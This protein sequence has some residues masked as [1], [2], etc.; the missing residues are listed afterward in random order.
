MAE[1][2]ADSIEHLMAELA[3][4][5]VRLNREVVIA[6]D[7]TPEGQPDDMRGLV[8]TENEIDALSAQPD[9]LLERWRRQ[10]RLAPTLAN[11]DQREEALRAE[12][13]QRTAASR[14]AGIPLALPFIAQQF[15][16]SSVE[17]DLLLIAVAPEIETR[18]ETLY[19][20]LQNDVT[21]KRPSADL[22]LH[23]VS[24]S[25]RDKLGNRRLLVEGSTLVA[26]HLILLGEEPHDRQPTFFRR[27]LKP[28]EGVVGAVLSRGPEH[29]TERALRLPAPPSGAPDVAELTRRQLEQLAAQ[30]RAGVSRPSIVRLVGARAD[31]LRSTADWLADTLRRSAILLELDSLIKDPER[32]SRAVRDAR[33]YGSILIVTAP[34]AIDE[35]LGRSLGDAETALWRALARFPDLVV[36][37]GDQTTYRR[38]PHGRAVWRV[39][40]DSPG[41][42]ARR[43]RWEDA[44]RGTLTPDEVGRLASTFRFGRQQIDHVVS[45]SLSAARLRDPS[46]VQ[47]SFSDILEAG[48]IATSPELGR[49][50]VRVEPRYKW[51]DLILPPE[52]HEQLRRLADWVR[53]RHT[54]HD[55]WGFGR[56]LSRGKGL[57]VLFT[58]PSGTGKTMAAEV[59]AGELGL[60]LFQIDLA[61][62]TSKYIGET[63]K[64]LST[65]FRKAEDCQAVLFFDEADALFGKRTEV[66]DAHDR[67]ANIEVNFLLQRV[68]QYE[69]IVI[70]ASNLQRNLDDAFLRRLHDVVEFPFPNDSLRERMWRSHVPRE[71]RCEKDIDYA[72]LGRQFKITGGSIKNIVLDAAFRAASEQRPIGMRDLIHATKAELQKQGRLPSKAEFDVWYDLIVPQPTTNERVGR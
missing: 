3:R 64:N 55:E 49:F 45:L 71:A 26:D 50:T 48:R 28:H 59:L 52:K 17:I 36:L 72:F 23:L 44:L 68:E 63:E 29:L 4:L 20:Y 32:G 38:L 21:R 34:E 27:Y 14:Q 57:N 5:D 31:D 22:A 66:K 62:V 7:A 19:A 46:I 41:Y 61:S 10:E 11:F 2:Y 69:G 6:R 8:I 53:H 47:P 70:L 43:R 9:Y 58:G 65:I 33:L 40:I 56:K 67:Y 18:Y 24:R 42:L 37:A 60:D 25:L 35:E 1:P 30:L 39:E 54:V 13:D 12:I 15:R 51:T 16:L